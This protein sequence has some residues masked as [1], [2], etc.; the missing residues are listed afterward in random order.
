V[1]NIQKSI[2]AVLGI[3]A[4]ATLIVP[5]SDDSVIESPKPAKSAKVD[6]PPPPAAPAPEP[7]PDGEY[8]SQ[9]GEVEQPDE[10]A[11]FG[12]PMMDA[13]PIDQGPVGQGDYASSNQAPSRERP[14]GGVDVTPVKP[15]AVSVGPPPT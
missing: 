14:R 5:G 4:F 15:G 8:A 6:V 11:S 1:D 9:D 7:D 12:Q 2:L 10:Y 13:S 3:A